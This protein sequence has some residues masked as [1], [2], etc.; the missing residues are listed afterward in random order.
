MQA[1]PNTGITGTGV[2]TP[3][4]QDT[5]LYSYAY[6]LFVLVTHWPPH[7]LYLINAEETKIVSLTWSNPVPPTNLEKK[8]VADRFA[9]APSSIK[10]VLFSAAIVGGVAN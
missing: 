7:A 2:S 5:G 10:G 8:L 4:G 6:T 3:S 1:V 9:V